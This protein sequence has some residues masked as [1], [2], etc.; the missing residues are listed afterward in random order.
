MG[1]VEDVC[2]TAGGDV[3]VRMGFRSG[4]IQLCDRMGRTNTTYTNLCTCIY[5]G[6]C[7]SELIPGQYLAELCTECNEIKVVDMVTH[8][9]HKAYSGIFSISMNH[10]RLYAMCSSPGEG[11]LLVWHQLS[12]AVIQLQWNE[13]QKQLKEVRRVHVPGDRVYYMCY[14]PQADLLIL[15]RY[16]GVVQA[17]KLQESAGQDPVWQLQW[18]EE[19]LGKKVKPEGVSC[20]SEGRVYVADG[21]NSRV[22]VLNGYTGEVIQEL[23]KDAGL[24]SV[25]NVCCLSNP[26]QLLV[27]HYPPPD[28][29]PTL[30]LYNITSL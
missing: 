21:G 1:L 25:F 23:L 9:V 8:K 3:A 29:K 7:I 28:K 12:K 2:A 18:G 24:G 6:K 15:S 11:S 4:E 10:A 17:V 16:G 14:M 22:L 13:G 26:H 20:D 30:S 19:V 27:Y 5:T